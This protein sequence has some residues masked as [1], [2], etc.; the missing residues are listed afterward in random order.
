[1]WT[2]RGQWQGD[3]SIT[4]SVIVLDDA[5]C[6]GGARLVMLRLELLAGG[7]DAAVPLDDWLLNFAKQ[8]K[9]RR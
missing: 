5:G 6:R 7:D 4:L 3:L 2:L 1:L 9:E 8:L